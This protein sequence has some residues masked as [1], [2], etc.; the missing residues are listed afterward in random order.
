MP[1]SEKQCSGEGVNALVYTLNGVLWLCKYV[2]SAFQAI[3]EGHQIKGK[4]E[5]PWHHW[6]ISFRTVGSL[7]G[8]IDL[9]NFGVLFIVKLDITADGS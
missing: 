1:C 7:F 5:S 4:K 9:C 6:K 3:Q 2:A 8:H